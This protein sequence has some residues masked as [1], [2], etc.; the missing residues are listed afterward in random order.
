MKL[1]SR[2]K[3]FKFRYINYKYRVLLALMLVVTLAVAVSCAYYFKSSYERQDNRAAELSKASLNQM[4]RQVSEQMDRVYNYYLVFA[5]K[6]EVTYLVDNDTDYSEYSHLEQAMNA[7]SGNNIVS[8]Y[9]GGY[10][11]INFYTGWVLSSKG[12]YTLSET[13][14]IDEVTTLFDYSVDSISKNYWIYLN[15]S[16]P[17]ALERTYRTTVAMDGLNLIMKLPRIYNGAKAMLIVNI[18]MSAISKLAME[19]ISEGQE[20]V[21][22]NDNN[23]IVYTTNSEMAEYIVNNIDQLPK[24]IKIGHEKYLLSYNSS[25]VSE[26][27][28]YV[29]TKSSYFETIN[30]L[31]A[32]VVVVIIALFSMIVTFLAFRWIYKPVDTMVHKISDVNTNKLKPGEDELEY[33][34]ESMEQLSG[35]NTE[36]HKGVTQLFQRR[37]M[38][39]ELSDTEIEDYLNRLSLQNRINQYVVV[40]FILRADSD[41]R[42]ITVEEEKKALYDIAAFLKQNYSDKLLMEPC[43]FARA[44]FAM[45]DVKE[46]VDG[47]EL[48]ISVYEA[49]KAHIEGQYEGL[50]LGTG[51][52]SLGE[53]KE[54]LYN[55]YQESVL[56][57][58]SG[59]DMDKT[60]QELNESY[61]S[62][63]GGNEFGRAISYNKTFEENVHKAILQGSKDD[64]YLITDE[65]IKYLQQQKLAREENVIFLIQYVNAIVLGV[66]EHNIDPDSVF[67]ETVIRIYQSVMQYYDLSRIRRYIKAVMIDPVIEKVGTMTASSSK[68][69]MDG[70]MKLIDER[71]G[72]ITLTECAEALGY[73][74]TYLWKV[75]K[76]EKDMSF[77]DY[78]E[79]YKV[80]LAKKLL[81]ETDLTVTQIAAKLNYTNAQNFIRFFSKKEGTTPGK[82]RQSVC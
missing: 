75:L 39:G 7:L 8:D 55:C 65:F 61:C 47:K 51:I 76:Q 36:L 12:M 43:Y 3:N 35:S 45:L 11:F 24:T 63:Y 77:T 14:N 52:S 72:D 56:A 34:T 28:F 1:F 54:M 60:S 4:V 38:Q 16:N 42:S 40:A 20:L 30:P 50:L 49:V 79:E 71:Q 22:T 10:T 66:K 62:Y 68:Q 82:Y 64:A 69:I 58:N 26:L 32:F 19:S 18:N 46:S 74:P 67:K 29:T 6:D 5:N 78:V 73:H 25:Q 17:G 27:N 2:V 41:E 15:A 44:I 33:I 57:L 9:V 13:S 23:E 21:I 80:N 81:K 37:L 53:N 48:S 70:I 59:S 31:Y